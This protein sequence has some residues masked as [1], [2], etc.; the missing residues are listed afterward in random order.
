MSTTIENRGQ[1][2]S[3][4]GFI[5]SAAGSAVGLGNIWKF[6][7]K[8][9][10]NGG[11]SFLVIYIL[12]VAIIGTTVM[13]AEFVL[14]RK[15]QK[16]AIGALR[17][18]NEKYSWVGGLGVLTGFIIL[19]YY[20]Q[21]GGWTIKYIIAYLTESA[22]VYADPTAYFLNMLGVNGFPLQGA[23]I[24]PL[25]F[26]A[27]TSFIISRGVADGIEKLSKFLMP[28]LFILLIGL[29]IRAC[30]LPGAGEG[31]AYMLHFDPSKINGNSFLVALG[32]AFFS[33]SLG[34]GVMITYA[35][36]LSKEDNLISNTGVVCVLDTCVA[37]FAGFMIIPAVCATGIDPGMGGGFAFAT[38][39]GVFMSIPGGT[40]FGLLFYSLLFFAAIT[41]SIS[42]LEGTVA[43]LVEEK[44][45]ERKKT[46][47]YVSMVL[48]V[49]GVFY[50]LSQ[51]YMNI[52]GIWWSL[53]G[54]QFPILGDFMEYLTD[55]LL[56]P[57]GAF[58][59]TV[60]VGWI[61]G[62]DN[63]IKE[64]TSDGKYKF[65]LAPAWAFLVKF[66]APIAILCI[67]IAGLFL[68]MSIA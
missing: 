42:I 22:T 3:K 25:I 9:Y 10:N 14:G 65:S 51:A 20:C 26:L 52:K 28:L 44:G 49:I 43:F 50:T 62:T 57:F 54:V 32:Q 48:F 37:L 18:L 11:G 64:A 63:A 30:T 38:L 5:L 68:G 1:F 58:F 39:A 19:C 6:P 29:M 8:A 7:G 16:N 41:S 21:V 31:V 34:M 17:E 40:I 61:W 13:L 66:A 4:L 45:M 56:L 23:I 12:M 59:T 2:G 46:V 36:Y 67:I 27:L 24:F 15:T 33:L 35:S 47:V 55:R 60:F 53:D